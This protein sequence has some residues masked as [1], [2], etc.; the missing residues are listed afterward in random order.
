MQ[1]IDE[2]EV[3]IMIFVHS[4]LRSVNVPTLALKYIF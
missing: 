4:F 2:N 1:F 3:F